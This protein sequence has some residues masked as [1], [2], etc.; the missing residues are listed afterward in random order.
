[1]TPL[2]HDFGPLSI[3]GSCHRPSWFLSRHQ[4]SV[5]TDAGLSSALTFSDFC[6]EAAKTQRLSKSSQW[7]QQTRD[8][9]LQREM[10]SSSSRS[11]GL[12]HADTQEAES[13]CKHPSADGGRKRRSSTLQGR[14]GGEEGVEGRRRGREEE[15]EGRRRTVL[16]H[17]SQL[18][19]Q[20]RQVKTTLIS[21]QADPG[22]DVKQGQKQIRC[23][24]VRS[25]RSKI[26]A[27]PTWT[28]TTTS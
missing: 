3:Q 18:R 5:R 8:G 1:M 9:D 6:S 24:Q 28:N 11:L 12:L 19:I 27:G 4:S 15:E 25:N 22:S 13:A 23:E 14:R 2:Q 17:C 16:C 26:N 7:Q 10:S 20:E 21:T